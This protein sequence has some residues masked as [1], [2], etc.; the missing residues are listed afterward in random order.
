MTLIWDG[1]QVV[2]M[3]STLS[4]MRVLQDRFAGQAGQAGFQSEDDVAEYVN[5]M[6]HEET[7]A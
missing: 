4:A 5:A 1:D 6:R 2:V 7:V 3:N